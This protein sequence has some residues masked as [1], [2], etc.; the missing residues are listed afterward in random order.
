MGDLSAFGA[1]LLR[2]LNGPTAVCADVSRSPLEPS[3]LVLRNVFHYALI[4][5]TFV[6]TLHAQVA[7]FKLF[8]AN[9][10]GKK[11]FKNV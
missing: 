2:R 3:S 11:A 4:R 8:Q 10:T 9:G 1:L 6:E 7:A 5:I